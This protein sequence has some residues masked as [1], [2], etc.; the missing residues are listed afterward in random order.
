M[1]STLTE[2]SG[3]CLVQGYQHLLWYLVFAGTVI[4]TLTEVSGSCLVQLY[5]H[6]LWYLVVVW[7]NGFVE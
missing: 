6:L 5:Q 2:V 3:S 1:I 4:S 7:D